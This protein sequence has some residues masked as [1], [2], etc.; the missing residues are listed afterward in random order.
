MVGPRWPPAGARTPKGRFQHVGSFASDS[1]NVH[2]SSFCLIAEIVKAYVSKAESWNLA[3]GG[4]RR[5]CWGSGQT[6]SSVS[7]A[8]AWYQVPRHTPCRDSNMR[9]KKVSRASCTESRLNP[10]VLGTLHL[11]G[12]PGRFNPIPS[13]AV[14]LTGALWPIGLGT[15]V[16]RT[17]SISPLP[18]FLPRTLMFPKHTEDRGPPLLGGICKCEPRPNSPQVTCGSGDLQMRELIILVSC[19]ISRLR[20]REYE[21]D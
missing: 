11:L 4:E 20:N 16:Y 12:V 6:K 7:W 15:S 2:P 19:C 1:A 8:L 3:L 5:W 13:P 9:K 17:F 21:A 10:R 14:A 18:A